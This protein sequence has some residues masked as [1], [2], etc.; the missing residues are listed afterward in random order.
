MRS[1]A[2][3]ERHGETARVVS[4]FQWIFSGKSARIP[5]TAVGA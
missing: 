3:S 4:G 1:A 5:D 2:A